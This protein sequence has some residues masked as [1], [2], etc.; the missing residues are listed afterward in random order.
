[1]IPSPMHLLILLFLLSA[2]FPFRRITRRTGK[3]SAWWGL[4]ILLLFLP[5]FCL[6]T[7]VFGLWI[8]EL[9]WTIMQKMAP[10]VPGDP[11]SKS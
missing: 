5:A 9:I 3:I 6:V 1:M 4:L 8:V 7:V 10:R 11:S 2:I